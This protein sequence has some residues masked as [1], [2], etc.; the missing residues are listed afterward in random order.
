LTFYAG[1]AEWQARTAA[2]AGAVEHLRDPFPSLLELVARTGP[3]ELAA[4][5]REMGPPD[6]DTLIS[7]YW[8]NAGPFSPLEFFARALLQP[9]AANLPGGLDC[10]WCRRPPQAGLLKPQG[11]GLAFEVICALCLRARAFPRSR[12]PGCNEDGEAK[13]ANFTAPEF[14]HLRLKACDSCRAYLQ[15]VDLSKDPAAIP[16]VDEM[17]GLPLDLWAI[18]NGYRKLQANLAGI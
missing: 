2:R 7:E 14:P 8:D 3:A 15:V 1:L 4:A 10:P 13:L 5:A 12:C 6:F 18:E 11:E 17:A 9:H 16:E